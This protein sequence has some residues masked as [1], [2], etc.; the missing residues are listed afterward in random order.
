MKKLLCVFP[1]L[2]F[3]GLITS[4]GTESTPVYTLTTSV[5]G[6]GTVTPSSGEFEKGETVTLTSTP[7]HDWEFNNWSGDVSG[8]SSTLTITMDRDKN[9]VGNFI[10]REYSI[11]YTINGNGS[12][13]E[14]IIQ[15]KSDYTVGTVVQLTPIPDTG[16]GF[17]EWDNWDG[18]VDEENGIVITVEGEV[19]LTVTFERIDYSLTITIEGEGEV[20]Q[21][22]VSTPKST[23]YPFETA[24][25]LTPVPSNGWK[26]V[27]WSGDVSSTD[28][29]IQVT[30]EEDININVIFEPLFYIHTNG[31]TVMCPNTKVGDTGIVDGVEYES[32]DRDLLILRR[33]EGSDLTRVCVSLVTNM[34][35]MFQ[36][37]PFN[38]SIGRWDV[39]SV[40]D[41]SF[42][43]HKSDF[44]QPIGE[45]D[46]S[47]VTDMS[48]MFH[49]TLFNQSIGKWNVS[50]VTNMINMFRESPF[51]QHIGEWDV[52]G[53]ININGIFRDSHFNQSIGNWDVSNVTGMSWIFSGTPFN[54]PI[55]E[56]DVSNVTDMS[57]MFSGT[58]FNQP[59]GEWDVSNVRDMSYMFR[60][61]HFTQSIG[62][63]DVSS[64][65]DMMWMFRES[66][67]NQPIGEW[68]VRNVRDMRWMFRESPF[69][70]P[71]GEWDVRNVRE[72]IGMFYDSPF[73]QPVEDWNVSSVTDMRWMFS[74]SL[75]N[76]PINTWCVAN[77]TSEPEDFSTG[78]PLT[79][80][81][82][83]IWGTCPD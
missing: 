8:E 20:V 25:E 45:W 11:N 82:K 46:V 52:S 37:S 59:I 70:Q 29:V 21:E 56:W 43:F 64:V 80:E 44:N 23:E 72:M 38:Q 42:M 41:M 79:E 75:F 50:N 26:F 3:F 19:N 76:Q 18:E 1:I 35:R 27:E 39:S 33:D 61:S 16:W 51:N 62:E 12:V 60:D 4:C 78:S 71:I 65:R 17:V 14:T 63:W 10:E 36:D 54:Q 55:G 28:K 66:P 58:L 24:V 40:T 49:E 34:N 53:V 67:F 47:N 15:S 32:V 7:S 13:E 30:I 6:E 73:N 9:I 69:N 81:N 2:I 5:N 83:P 31:V 22:I 77:I 57:W 68:D 74:G 48:W